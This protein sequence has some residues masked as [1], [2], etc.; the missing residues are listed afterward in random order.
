MTIR[1]SGLESA[2]TLARILHEGFVKNPGLP[3]EQ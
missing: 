3:D 1:S 2:Q